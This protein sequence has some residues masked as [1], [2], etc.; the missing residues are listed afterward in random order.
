M[1]RLIERGNTR[2]G[3]H[4]PKEFILHN[5]MVR[6]FDTEDRG[7]LPLYPRQQLRPIRQD[8]RFRVLLV[9]HCGHLPVFFLAPPACLCD[10]ESLID[11]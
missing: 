4:R 10:S 11:H 3:H 9:T 6:I 1:D 8:P 7:R 5:P 2:Y